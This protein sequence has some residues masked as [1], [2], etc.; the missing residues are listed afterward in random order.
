MFRCFTIGL[1]D[2]NNKTEKHIIL[3]LLDNFHRI[4]KPYFS[5]IFL[6]RYSYFECLRYYNYCNIFTKRNNLFGK[7]T[8]LR[9]IVLR[10][11]A[12]CIT[13]IYYHL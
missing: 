7:I 3:K 12:N 5:I 6:M 2:D 9:K 10:L 8:V 1:I 4:L 11:Y 13:N